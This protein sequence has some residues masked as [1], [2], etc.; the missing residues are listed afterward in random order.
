MWEHVAWAGFAQEELKYSEKARQVIQ[1][2]YAGV[3]SEAKQV[4]YVGFAL[5]APVYGL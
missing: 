1:V 3:G 4:G 5:A 2:G